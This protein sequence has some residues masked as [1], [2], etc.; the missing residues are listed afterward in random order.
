VVVVLSTQP[1][2]SQSKKVPGAQMVDGA[3]S[4]PQWAEK[5]VQGS[6]VVVVVVVG[7]PTPH[8]T[9]AQV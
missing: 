7:S 8:S 2:V 6:E 1:Q 9:E 4:H 5:Q 3:P